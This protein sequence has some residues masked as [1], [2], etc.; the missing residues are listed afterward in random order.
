MSEIKFI[1][2]DN[3]IKF[4]EILS[5]DFDIYLPD[6]FQYLKYNNS[7]EI[8]TEILNNIRTVVPVLKSVLIKHGQ[9]LKEEPIQNIRPVIIFGAK[10]CDIRAKKALDGI[11][12]KGICPDPFYNLNNENLIIFSWDC[13]NP[14]EFC[15]CNL[16]GGKPY[17]ERSNEFFDLN[18]SPVENGFVVEVGSERGEK[19][20]ND[21]KGFFRD[22]GE[23]VISLREK[24]RKNAVEI[25][26]KN[27]SRFSKIKNTNLSKILKE[28]FNSDKWKKLSEKCVQCAGCNNS[29]PSC[30]CFFLGET[31][32][33]KLNEISPKLRFWDA[34]HNTAYARVAG[35]A[36]PRKHLYERF[37]NRYEC[38]FNYRFENF[39]MYACSGCGRCITVCP[40]K[41]DIRE[42][43][44]KV[45]E[46]K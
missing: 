36:N 46:D 31:Q 8:D 28:R 43:L 2:K 34:C 15:F 25:L 16:V 13:P 3:L 32:N 44:I 26:E 19:I 10:W 39:G 18:F 24:T 17:L 45:I 22:V 40:A 7:S 12:L 27:N 35:G 41:I 21:C 5:Q 6:G 9:C 23:S 4:I 14:K 20:I 37:R 1:Q 29:C 38:K 11:Y 30:Y 33:G 42:T